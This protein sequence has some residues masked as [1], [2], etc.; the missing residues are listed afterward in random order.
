MQTQHLDAAGTVYAFLNAV[1]A[2]DY[3]AAMTLIAEDC[4]YENMPLGKVT[5]P[6]GVRGVQAAYVEISLLYQTIR[7]GFDQGKSSGEIIGPLAEV[8]LLAID[9]LGKGRGSLFELETLDEL[10]A[11]RYN[12]GRVTLFATNYSL[13]APEERGRTNGYQSTHDL[14]EAARDSKVLSDRV[15]DRIYSRL[16]EMCEFIELPNDTPD[17]R[18]ARVAPARPPMR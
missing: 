17:H 1:K 11:R 3:D 16:C 2:F 5:G 13:I 18:R 12:A 6:A 7:R 15:G 9:E 4:D 10:I 8:E 14:K